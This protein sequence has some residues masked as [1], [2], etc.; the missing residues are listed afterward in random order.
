MLSFRNI[1]H[2]FKSLKRFHSTTLTSVDKLW[3]VQKS[4]QPV[5]DR[6]QLHRHRKWGVW[7]LLL[8]HNSQSCG[9]RGGLNKR[10]LAQETL[11]HLQT[12][13]LLSCRSPFSDFLPTIAVLSTSK[14]F[15]ATCLSMSSLILVFF[16]QRAALMRSAAG[17]AGRQTPWTQCPKVWQQ[18]QGRYETKP[19]VTFHAW[20]T[21]GLHTNWLFVN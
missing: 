10:M 16:V 9:N 5:S 20:T 17:T 21:T 12:C 1:L 13:K 8:G 3:Q 15:Y 4:Q 18:T 19:W 2:S 7:V 6:K 11:G 14:P